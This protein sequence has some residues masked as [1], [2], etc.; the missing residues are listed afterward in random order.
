MKSTWDYES[1]IVS[2]TFDGKAVPSAALRRVIESHGYGV[3]EVETPSLMRKAAGE[4]KVRVP[5]SAPAQLREAFER[6]AARDCVVVVDF[7]ATWCAPCIKLKKTTLADAGVKKLLDVVELVYVD[8]D[9]HPQLGKLWG[10]SS[11]PDIFLVA[12]DGRVIDRLRRYEEAEPF[13]I[14]LDAAI[15]KHASRDNR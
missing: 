1:D 5:E 10:V 3:E 7:W 8:L 9:E 11:V 13:K 12:P 14:R 2:I 6:G 4:G 15:R